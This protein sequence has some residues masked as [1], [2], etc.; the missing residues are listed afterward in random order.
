[1]VSLKPS[2]NCR[3][4][5]LAFLLFFQLCFSRTQQVQFDRV[6]KNIDLV[7][8]SRTTSSLLECARCCF[9]SCT[10]CS[11]FSFNLL[12]NS[13]NCGKF[14]RNDESQNVSDVLTFAANRPCPTDHGY[15]IYSVDNTEICIK[16]SERTGTYQN[17][18]D[19]CGGKQGVFVLDSLNRVNLLK[20]LRS[21]EFW[22]GLTH[23]GPGE[24]WE[25]ADGRMITA[26]EIAQFLGQSGSMDGAGVETCAI[27]YGNPIFFEDVECTK[28]Y[29]WACQFH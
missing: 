12:N 3:Q 13:C 6:N 29:F 14:L 28:S 5:H 17:A 20:S 8:Q 16:I 27:T 25:W 7:V 23:V 2:A 10:D 18:I 24:Q 21:G 9:F 19:S 11:Y 22:P 4:L 15:D 26:P 1:M